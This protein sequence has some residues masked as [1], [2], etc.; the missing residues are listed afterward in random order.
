MVGLG[1]EGVASGWG[2]LSKITLKE[3]EQRRGKGKQRFKKG[4]QVGSR[5]ECLKKEDAGT[6][7]RTMIVNFTSNA[8]I[9]NKT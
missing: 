1:Q 7:L 3:A 8:F 5:G 6:P 4:G 9:K 2:E